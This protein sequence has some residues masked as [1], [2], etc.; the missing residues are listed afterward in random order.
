M[1]HDYKENG[2]Q[3]ESLNGNYAPNESPDLEQ[4]LKRGVDLLLDEVER[5]PN[6]RFYHIMG[7]IILDMRPWFYES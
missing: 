3:G 4:Q 6:P 7:G 2:N 5:V 1:V